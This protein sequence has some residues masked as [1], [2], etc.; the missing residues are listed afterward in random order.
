MSERSVVSDTRRII[1]FY[2]LS[3]SGKSYIGD[4]LSRWKSWPVYHADEDITPAMALALQEHR[5]FTNAMRDEFV[6]ILAG[7]LHAYQPDEAIVI[8]TQAL[9]KQRHRRYLRERVSGLELIAVEAPDSLLAARL[10]ARNDGISAE[11]AA[12]LRQD[13]EAPEPGD[14]VL[15]N[16]G[17]DQRIFEQLSSI[18][19]AMGINK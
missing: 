19:L 11:S 6:E 17:D 16:D 9:Y 18:L 14:Y 1:F 7:K 12:A 4:L 10:A 5:P 8:V 15:Q 3:A 13:F 2:G